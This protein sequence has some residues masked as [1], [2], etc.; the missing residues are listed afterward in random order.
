MQDR[1][2]Q[3]SDGLAEVQRPGGL[4]EKVAGVMQVRVNVA[5]GTLGAAGEQGPGVREHHGVVVHVHDAGPWIGLLGDLVRT[6]RH[7][8]A[9]ANVQELADAAAGEVAHYPP[10]K[11][12]VGAYPGNDLGAELHDLLPHR[13]VRREMVLSPEPEVADPRRVRS[14]RVEPGRG[15][16]RIPRAAAHECGGPTALR[17]RLLTHGTA[18]P[19]SPGELLRS[20]GRCRVSAKGACRGSPFADQRLRSATHGRHAGEARTVSGARQA[21]TVPL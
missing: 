20:R 2:Q 13:P 8:D 5:T 9:G 18:R 4:A 11:A 1:E 10:E 14:V 15:A 7:R 17:R 6:A 16:D 12:P 3:Y 21:H 19:R